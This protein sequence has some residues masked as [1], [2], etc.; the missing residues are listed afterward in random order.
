MELVEVDTA[1]GRRL[2]GLLH[3]PP[4]R[5]H[6][7]LLLLHGKGGNCYSGI[8]RFL[9]PRLAAAGVR[10]LA[11]NM[12]SHDLGYTRLDVPFVDLEVGRAS[13]DG[14][15]WEDLSVGERDVAA[16][17]AFLREHHGR[18]VVIAGHSSGGFYTALY[19]PGDAAVIGRILLSPLV[20]NRRP[21][22]H[23]FG[24]VQGLEVALA[25][26]RAMVAAGDGEQLHMTRTWYYAISARSL[27]QRAAE[28]QGLV[29][30]A[31]AAS[32]APVL[33]TW[34]S[35]EGRGPS[36]RELAEGLAGNVSVAVL[37]GA[38]HNYIGYEQ[39]VSDVVLSFLKTLT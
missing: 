34:G 24:G 15:M 3:E 35:R 32:T 21:L 22:E 27:L 6:A 14:G 11:L 33:L 13:T 37:E 4:Q 1:D 28:P 17:V 25:R 5:A 7:N 8:C 23:W 29:Q 26:A 39:T 16:G 30:R 18:G 31:L 36:W 2:E 9:P 10:T 19:A 12:R 38:E 20:S